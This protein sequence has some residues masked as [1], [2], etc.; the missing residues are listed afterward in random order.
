MRK[1]TLSKIIY[2]AMM[3]LFGS[4]FIVSAVLLLRYAVNTF[5]GKQLFSELAA[6]HTTSADG[7]DGDSLILEE[8]QAMEQ[9]LETLRRER[10]IQLRPIYTAAKIVS[11]GTIEDYFGKTAQDFKWTTVA[12]IDNA[13]IA[14]IGD[15]VGQC[16]IEN[17]CPDAIVDAAKNAGFDMLLTANNHSYDTGTVGA[18]RTIEIIRDRGLAMTEQCL[19]EFL[20][21][22]VIKETQGSSS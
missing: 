21:T 14:I 5:Q 17:P 1:K 22:S 15:R 8:L 12:A 6:M 20:I 13:L 18:H 2:W 11:E 3:A 19:L 10:K 7:P 4:V 9:S 16:P